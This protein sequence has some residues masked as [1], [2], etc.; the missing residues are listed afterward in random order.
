L[1]LVEQEHLQVPMF[2]QLLMELHPPLDR[3]FQLLV[4]EVEDLTKTLLAMEDREDLV[5]VVVVLE[6]AVREE[7]EQQGHQDKDM[8]AVEVPVLGQ[9]MV[10][11]AVVALVELDHLAI[12][13][14]EEMVVLV[15]NFPQHLE[16]QHHQ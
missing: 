15:F 2:Q 10:L 12:L 3:Q 14:V 4:V 16:T 6:E 5:E 1:D 9:H 11:A 8:M 7:V 13:A